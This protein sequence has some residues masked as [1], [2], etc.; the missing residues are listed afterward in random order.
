LTNVVFPLP[1]EYRVQLYAD[2]EFL[3][4]RRIVVRDLSEGANR[5]E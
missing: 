1:G 3:I 5:D 2:R 4:E